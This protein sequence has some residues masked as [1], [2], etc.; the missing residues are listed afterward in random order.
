MQDIYS[1][2]FTLNVQYEELYHRLFLG[3]YSK[4]YLIYH[5]RHTYVHS[6]IMETCMPIIHYIHDIIT[7][8]VGR[9]WGWQGGTDGASSESVMFSFS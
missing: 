2:T 1:I 4:D 5:L 9:K 8:G 7:F 3:N 6:K